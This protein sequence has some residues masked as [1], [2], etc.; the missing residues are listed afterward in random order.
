MYKFYF[1]CIKCT[2]L[3]KIG[4]KKQVYLHMLKKMSNFAAVK[5]N[6]VYD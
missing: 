3:C 1:Y 5:V 2:F 6:I 4:K